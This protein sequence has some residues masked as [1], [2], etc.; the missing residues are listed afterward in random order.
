MFIIFGTPR[1]GTTLLARILNSH[2][3]VI[4]PNETDFIVPLAFVFSRN[5]SPEIGKTIIS[6][7]T[8]KS[9]NFDQSIGKYIS[10]AEVDEIIFSGEYHSA[11]I[12]SAIYRQ[13]AANAGV[14]I[15]GDKSPN[16]ID[17][18]KVLC[19]TGTLESIKIVHII[20]DVR[21]VMV[22]LMKTGWL[23]D[24]NPYF[25]RFWNNS[26]L[27]LPMKY[28]S[29]PNL[30]LQVRY[31]DLV[32]NPVTNVTRICNFL[33]IEFQANMLGVNILDDQYLG[34]IY[35]ENLLEKPITAERIGVYKRE[36]SQDLEILY[37]QQ[38]KEAMIAF[39]YLG[40]N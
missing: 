13:I 35:H 27:Y 32:R 33:E 6:E 16:D 36:L 29:Q 28:K 38:A 39:G 14:K 25:P 8:T 5:L 9:P 21:D 11:R 7:F 20:R 37:I 31:E 26:N 18:A 24:S 2:K 19:E 40:S 30:Y 22:S 15:S 23:D 17:F 1:S 10:K 3:D 12:L 4:I 34:G